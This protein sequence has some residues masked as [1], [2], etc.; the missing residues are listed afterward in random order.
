MTGDNEET[1]NKEFLLKEKLGGEQAQA[2]LAEQF[3]MTCYLDLS[4][5]R[6]SKERYRQVPYA[7]AKKHVI[8]PV[9]DQGTIVVVAVADPLNLSPLEELRFFLNAEI[10]AVYSP[11]DVILSAIHDCYNTEHG[12]ASQLIAGMGD[13]SEEGKEGDIE[14]FDLFDQSKLQSPVVQLLNLILTEAIQQGA[15]DIHFEP[16]ENGM[17]V[18]Y[19]IDGVLQNRHA[20]SQDYQTQLLTRIKVMSKLD[21]AEHRLPQDG[22]IKLRMGRR[23]VDFRVSTVPIAGGE[24]IVLRILDKGN[25]LLGLDKIGMLPSVFEQ[26][27]KLVS[28]PEGIVLVTGPTGSGKTTTLYSAICDM[29]NDEIN[30]MTIEDPVEYNLRGI[31]QIGVHHKIKLDFATGLR[32]IL[33]QD[34]DV[35]MVGEIRDKETAE[36]AI[37]AALTG[38]LV[39]STLHTNDA[40]SAITRLVDMGIEPYLLSSCIV[41]VLAQRLV[42]RICSD[43]KET[44]EPSPRELQSLGIRS[45]ELKNGFLYRGKGCSSCYGTGFKGRQGVY[46]LMPVNHAINKQIVQSPDAIEMRKVALSQGMVS[47]LGHGAELVKQGVSTVAEVLRVARG[48][49]EEG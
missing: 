45:E 40:P 9:E 2:K 25:V 41:G 30:I 7:F 6:V 26:F 11:R 21:I 42:R 33:R 16:S 15:S 32:H 28:L 43:C 10:E 35:I 19:R 36:I 49:E 39:L 24:R 1:G 29:T 14:I 37:Q 31:A 48:I 38:H 27:Q 8:L 20:P 5:F 34:P 46:E 4:S 12:A 22:R 47:L 18:R 17:R 23:E 13:K 44:Y 3:G